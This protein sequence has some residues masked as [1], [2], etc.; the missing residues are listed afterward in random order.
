MK[1]IYKVHWT[2]NALLELKKTFVYLEENFTGKELNVLALEI[3]K[4]SK[5]LS[6]NPKLFPIVN[7]ELQIRRAVVLKFNN[8]YYTFNENGVYVLSFYSN[9]Q[10]TPEF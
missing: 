9:R 10:N 7:L 8:L 4:V 2:E 1:S 6:L 3:E 5:L